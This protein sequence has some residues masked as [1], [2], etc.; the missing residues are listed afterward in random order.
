[1]KNH[2]SRAFFAMHAKDQQMLEAVWKAKADGS[3]CSKGWYNPFAING[4]IR[5]G[6]PLD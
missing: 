6:K 5:C 1:M 2:T 4:D 3:C